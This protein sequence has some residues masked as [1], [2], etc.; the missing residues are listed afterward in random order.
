MVLNQRRRP[1]QAHALFAA[2]GLVGGGGAVGAAQTVPGYSGRASA[3]CVHTV[4]CA[5]MQHEQQKAQ[6]PIVTPAAVT[7]GCSVLVLHC[8]VLV[9][10]GFLQRVCSQLLEDPRRTRMLAA[11]RW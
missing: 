9:G 11:A 5:T 4:L 8:G 10:W 3:P 6:Q 7:A 1:Q 2:A